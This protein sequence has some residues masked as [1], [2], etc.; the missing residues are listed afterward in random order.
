[1]KK[2]LAL[3]LVLVMMLSF[4][5]CTKKADFFEE[6]LEDADYEVEVMD[7]GDIEDAFDEAEDEGYDDYM[8]YLPFD[9][10]DVKYLVVGFNEDDEEFVA[11]FCFNKKDV[12]EESVEELED[13]LDDYGMYIEYALDDYGIDFDIDDIVIEQKGKI[14]VVASSDDAYDAAYGK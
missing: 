9:A 14:V 12:A 5:A 6:N 10:E 4:V 3:A 7:E 11:V 2:I 1:M 8:D 13:A